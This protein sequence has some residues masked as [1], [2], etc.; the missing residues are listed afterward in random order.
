MAFS[1]NL[2]AITF[3][4]LALAATLSTGAIPAFA[5]GIAGHEVYS[6][7][8]VFELRS[9]P[10]LR[11]AFTGT[12]GEVMLT[13]SI[14]Q[15]PP[16]LIFSDD[17]ETGD[18]GRWSSSTVPPVPAGTRLHFD[19]SQCPSGWTATEVAAGRT[20]VGASSDASIGGTVRTALNDLQPQHHGHLVDLTDWTTAELGN[21]L[22][23]HHHAWST[24]S[25]GQYTSW[26]QFG[27]SVVTTQWGNGMDSDG[28]GNYPYIGNNHETAYTNAV[29]TDPGSRHRHDSGFDVEPTSVALNTALPYLQLLLCEKQ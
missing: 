12:A 29:D 13:G 20:I 24:R 25:D 18:S 22:S 6:S 2:R 1:E 9:S 11:R 27:N 26:D 8:D 17:F 21:V 7:G 3:L 28:S 23:P 15:A 16:G 10:R 4:A 14:T 5:A 19:A